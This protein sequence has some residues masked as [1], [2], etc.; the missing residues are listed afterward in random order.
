MDDAFVLTAAWKLAD[1]KLPLAERMGAAY[2]EAALSVTITTVTD[3]ISFLIGAALS[4]LHGVSDFCLFSGK[5]AI[6][7]RSHIPGLYLV[8]RPLLAKFIL[9]LNS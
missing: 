2:Q 4:D 1:T 5:N 8:S 3:V 9:W 6:F 7:G